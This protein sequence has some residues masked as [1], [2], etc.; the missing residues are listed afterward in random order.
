MNLHRVGAE[1]DLSYNLTFLAYYRKYILV[2]F[3]NLDCGCCIFSWV[4]IAQIVT[5]RLWPEATLQLAQD[6][7]ILR[8]ILMDAWCFKGHTFCSSDTFAHRR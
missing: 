6:H 4:Y 1:A 5:I 3:G 8:R 7:T 2:S